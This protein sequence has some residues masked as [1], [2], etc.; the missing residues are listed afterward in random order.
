[1][2][3]RKLV[4][5]DI[6]KLF[7]DFCTLGL[8]VGARLQRRAGTEC[9]EVVETEKIPVNLIWK[10]EFSWCQMFLFFSFFHSF[11]LDWRGRWWERL[12]IPRP[13]VK[14]L[15]LFCFSTVRVL[16]GCSVLQEALYHHWASPL[17]PSAAVLPSVCC[18]PL[19]EETEGRWSWCYFHR[20]VNS[21]TEHFS[22]R[23][24][25]CLV[26]WEDV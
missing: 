5:C 26:V 24:S 11:L 25:L 12:R 15:R 7:L 20:R 19:V 3:E 4:L 23:V 14:P 2:K 16:V 8:N 21:R 13:P 10:V 17:V 6:V 9:E 22:S 18:R 1:M